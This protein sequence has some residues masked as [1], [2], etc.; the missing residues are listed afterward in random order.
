[1]KTLYFA[2]TNQ[3]KIASMNRDLA[4]LDIEVLPVDMDIPEPRSEETREIAGHKVR[5]AFE[6]IQKPCVAQDGGFYIPALNGFPKAFVNFA[7]ETIGVDG[8]LK[9]VENK[10][11][12]CEF[13]DTLAYLDAERNEPVFF[14]A[15]NKGTLATEPR[16][17]MHSYNWGPL[18]K[19]FIPDGQTKTLCEM[20]EE[21]MQAWL[22]TRANDWYGKQFAD[23]L[24]LQA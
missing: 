1:M 18:H 5:V 8:I 14:E 7:M 6:K 10:D 4:G 17:E 22:K 20:T 19:V 11:R 21:E 24:K 23:W 16:G 9:L 15:I 12:A 2:T 3:G 13:R